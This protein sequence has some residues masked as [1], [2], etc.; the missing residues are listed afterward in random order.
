MSEVDADDVCFE[1]PSRSRLEQDMKIFYSRVFIWELKVLWL[2]DRHIEIYFFS[3]PL[4][5]A[6]I[7]KRE[8]AFFDGDCPQRIPARNYYEN[9]EKRAFPERPKSALKRYLDKEDSRYY[10]YL[11][12]DWPDYEPENY[13]GD[14]DFFECT[15]SSLKEGIEDSFQVCLNDWTTQYDDDRLDEERGPRGYFSP[16]CD[17]FGE[18]SRESGRA[19]AAQQN[20]TS[21]HETRETEYPS[22][23]EEERE[24][25]EQTYGY[26][27]W[28]DPRHNRVWLDPLTY[29]KV[30]A[31]MVPKQVV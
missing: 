10:Q 14:F 5:I 12:G 17:C 27:V 2:D 9:S 31:M 13:D 7:K 30:E 1:V 22:T 21:T 8:R 19:A 25:M 26:V 28:A 29:Q 6:D 3:G 18:K 11:Q 24:L 4:T 20:F 23:M 15:M 16:D